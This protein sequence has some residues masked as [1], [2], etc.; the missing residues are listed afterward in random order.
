MSST[1]SFSIPSSSLDVSLRH[2]CRASLPRPL[3]FA[4][5]AIALHGQNLTTFTYTPPAASGLVITAMAVD[6]ARAP[7][8]GSNQEFSKLTCSCPRI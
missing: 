5:L 3:A 6:S 8:R 4:W 7:R 2:R 1:R